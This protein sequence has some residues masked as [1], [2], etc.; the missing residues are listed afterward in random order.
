MAL[1]IKNGNSLVQIQIQNT[2]EII[3]Y[4]ESESESN[5]P[6]KVGSTAEVVTQSGTWLSASDVG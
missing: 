1:I 4:S 5:C 3:K 6:K 2:C